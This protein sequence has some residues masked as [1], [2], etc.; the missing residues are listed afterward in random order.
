MT[1]LFTVYTFILLYFF[2]LNKKTEII[3]VLGVI[4]FLN[5]AIKVYRGCN[6]GK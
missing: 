6:S 5:K 1:I 4:F 3:D 2:F